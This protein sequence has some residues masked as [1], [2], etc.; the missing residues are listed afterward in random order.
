[1]AD[2]RLVAHGSFGADWVSPSWPPPCRT[3][4]RCGGGLV[5]VRRIPW[6]GL[7]GRALDRAGLERPMPN[8]M[9]LG[10]LR[11]R[12]RFAQVHNIRHRA[13]DPRR[14]SAVPSRKPRDAFGLFG[15]V[16]EL[17]GLQ[18]RTPGAP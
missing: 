4:D 13:P 1:M 12:A 14:H 16:D 9:N 2:R 15:T 5:S 3:A 17:E 7:S 10:D 18:R 11:R 6:V 8:V